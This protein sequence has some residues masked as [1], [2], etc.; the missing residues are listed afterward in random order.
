MRCNRALLPALSPQ[1][2]SRSRA[3]MA[4]SFLSPSTFVAAARRAQGPTAR[5]GQ[6]YRPAGPG[7]AAQPEP[8]LRAERW[9]PALRDESYDADGRGRPAVASE[10]GRTRAFPSCAEE[11]TR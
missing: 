10:A 11:A 3:V 8:R 9:R 7:T 4:F 2:E 6:D 1:L 5:P